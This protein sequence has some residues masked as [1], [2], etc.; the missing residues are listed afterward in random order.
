[1]TWARP[2]RLA[3]MVGE[4]L[5]LLHHLRGHVRMRTFRNA[6]IGRKARISRQRG[7]VTGLL[8]RK[9]CPVRSHFIWLERSEA[10]LHCM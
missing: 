10:F 1:M 4:R 3:R 5:I 7:F 9:T 2:N 6:E 8:D